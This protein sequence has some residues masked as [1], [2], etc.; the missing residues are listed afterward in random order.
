MGESAL[1][2]QNSPAKPQ[3]P[4]VI[5][6][7]GE[8]PWVKWRLKRLFSETLTESES[9]ANQLVYGAVMLSSTLAMNA[10][11]WGRVLRRRE[12]LRMT[13]WARV[14]TASSL[15]SSGIT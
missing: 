15:T 8:V 3:N 12:F 13:R 4:P 7:G 9:L 11:F 10:S 5:P 2:L 6:S 1:L 14:Q